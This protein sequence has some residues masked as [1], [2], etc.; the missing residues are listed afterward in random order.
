M[1]QPFYLKFFLIWKYLQIVALKKTSQEL[2][3]LYYLGFFFIY[4][5]IFISRFV[6][7]IIYVEWEIQPHISKLM[8][9]VNIYGAIFM[10]AFFLSEK[11]YLGLDLYKW[12]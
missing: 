7:Y 3:N 6:F 11:L 4:L 12:L 2:L 1:N 8:I 5:Y 10:L 9:Q